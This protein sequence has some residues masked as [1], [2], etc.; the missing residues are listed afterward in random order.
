MCGSI[1]EQAQMAC[2]PVG[3]DPA[4]LAAEAR[5]EVSGNRSLLNKIECKSTG[6]LQARLHPERQPAETMAV[7]VRAASKRRVRSM[8][9]RARSVR[10]RRWKV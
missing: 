5:L 9:Q 8:L 10:P 3:R 6:K 1:Q 7:R 4:S 2:T